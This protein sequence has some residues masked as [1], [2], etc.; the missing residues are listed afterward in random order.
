MLPMRDQIILSRVETCQP[1]DVE[2]IHGAILTPDVEE[3]IASDQ[4]VPK[5]LDPVAVLGQWSAARTSRETF[6]CA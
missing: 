1:L 2:N 3:V 6:E 4:F 5:F